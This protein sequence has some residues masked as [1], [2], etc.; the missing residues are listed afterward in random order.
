[1]NKSKKYTIKIRYILNAPILTDWGTYEYVKYDK[2]LMDLDLS[3]VESAIGHEATANYMTQILGVPIGVN[4][5][6]VAMKKGES[7]LVFSLKERL[8]EGCVLSCQDLQKCSF[9]LGILRKIK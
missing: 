1:M 5:I 3:E 7:A 4:R 9:D 2:I 8:P 6:K